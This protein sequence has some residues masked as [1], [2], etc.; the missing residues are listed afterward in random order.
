MQLLAVGLN[1]TT[2]P[3]SLREQ[4]ALAPDQLGRAVQAVAGVTSPSSFTRKL[5]VLPLLGA[6]RRGFG[7]RIFGIPLCIAQPCQ[8]VQ[9]DGSGQCPGRIATIRDWTTR[10]PVATVEQLFHEVTGKP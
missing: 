7:A 1:H 3:V 6:P 8:L 5:V 9:S 2:A 4:L 10:N